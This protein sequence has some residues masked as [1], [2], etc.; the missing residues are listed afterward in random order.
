MLELVYTAWD[1]QPFVRNV[2]YGGPQFAWDGERRARLRAELDAYFARQYGLTRK[3]LRYI[4]DPHDPT[5]RELEDIL[6]PANDPSDAPRTTDFPG[7]TFRRLK[8]RETKKYGEHRTKRRL[9]EAWDCLQRSH[10]PA[11][12]STVVPVF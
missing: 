6:G 4:L 7:E 12:N 11:A 1:S 10:A 9:L 2:G 5:D 3:Q 8:E